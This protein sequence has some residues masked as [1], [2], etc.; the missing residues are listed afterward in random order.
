MAFGNEIKTVPDELVTFIKTGSKFIIAGHKEPDG[1]C[2]G[3]QLALRSALIRLGKE[4]I[5]CSA[6]PFK[7]TE[8]KD[9]QNQIKNIPTE[10]DKSGAKLLIVDCSTL[11]RTGNLCDA[12]K[13]LPFAI[14]DHHA[15]VTHPPSTEQTPVY[16]D[17]N[18]PSCTILIEK[19]ISAFDL[20]MTAE[21][22]SLLLFGI[23][24]D[25]G[26]F[27]HLTEKS[28]AVFE[29]A[30]KMVR[31]GASPKKLFKV[32]HG[33][34]SLSSRIMTGNI[35]SRIESHCGGK[36]LISHETLEEFEK[37]GLEGRDSDIL[38]QMLLSIEN[39]EAVV[40][41][42]QE[43]KEFCTVSLRSSDKIDVARIAASFEGGGHK[44]AAGLT[45]K[46]NISNVK[47]IMLESFSKIL[48]K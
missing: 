23:C 33:G 34:K 4:A 32:M 29:A 15:S 5:V 46:D 7:R 26:F 17:A 36:L 22:A 9:Y 31:N 24:T 18:A 28:G 35:L 43:G 1:D 12:I 44:N 2:I 8:L 38:F 11:E 48:V 14:I 10:E 27:R 13:N 19:L 30:A 16:L 3:S 6:G 20:E 45:M 47:K 41:I 39:V 25:T 21:E 37:Y 40:I 42:R